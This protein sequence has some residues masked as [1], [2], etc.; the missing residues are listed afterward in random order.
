MVGAAGACS[1]FVSLDGLDDGPDAA[2]DSG[3][4]EQASVDAM[5]ASD[6]SAG[7]AMSAPDADAGA[8]A[9]PCGTKPGPPM[10]D[11][12]RGDCIDSTEV[13]NKQ[14]ADYVAAV[15]LGTIPT[16]P[17]ECSWNLSIVPTCG[18]D[19]VAR[20]NFPVECVDWCDAY[21]YCQW[22][23][24]RLCGRVDGG[25]R[26]FNDPLDSTTSQWFRACSANGT[27]SH[28]YGL[29]YVPG[30]CNTKDFSDS[31]S[32]VEVATFPQC[33]GGFAGLYDMGGNVEE[34]SDSCESLGE[35]GAND[36]CHESGDSVG[37]INTG[38]AQCDNNDYDTRN[39]AFGGVGIRC[40]SP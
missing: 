33:V 26:D 37:Y 17:P 13:T 4:D 12:G 22:A 18:Y 14:Y 9:N 28:P 16:Q 11:V 34:W 30:A 36:H 21:S 15:A 35:G 19:P 38:P 31:G 23:G 32:V 10:V 5:P 1:L 2:P 8:D 29:T 25:A 27:R 7:D 40:C 3:G 20:P 6:V 24:K 39:G